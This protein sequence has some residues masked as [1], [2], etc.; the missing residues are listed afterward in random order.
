MNYRKM[1]LTLAVL[2]VL[3]FSLKVKADD[4]S[5]S[6]MNSTWIMADWQFVP[7]SALL[8]TSDIADE[9]IGDTDIDTIIGSNRVVYYI[10]T[11]G[12]EIIKRDSTR[13]FGDAVS[14]QPDRETWEESWL[15][16]ITRKPIIDTIIVG[17]FYADTKLRIKDWRVR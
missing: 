6:T 1:L 16:T 8:D 13:W 9:M 14:L 10:D 4:I 7:N 3:P 5:D 2:L 15:I 17:Y 11:V 12:F